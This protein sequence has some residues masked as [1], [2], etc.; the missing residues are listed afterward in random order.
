MARKPSRTS[1]TNQLDELCKQIVRITANHICQKCGK[2][3]EKND[4]HTSH[5][6]PKGN[7]ASWRRFDPLNIQLLCFH[8]HT[9]WWH[10]NILEAGEWFLRAYPHLDEYLIIYKGGKPA[11]ISTPE[12]IDLVVEYKQKLKE[13]Q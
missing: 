4:A 2:Y 7:G 6:I 9:Q 1:L 10:K 8:C 13:L 12:M 11:K 5:V 3:V